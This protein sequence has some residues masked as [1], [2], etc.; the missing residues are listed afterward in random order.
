MGIFEATHPRRLKLIISDSL[1]CIGYHLKGSMIDSAMPHNEIDQMTHFLLLSNN[2]RFFQ[3]KVNRNSSIENLIFLIIDEVYA[4]GCIISC[5]TVVRVKHHQSQ[6]ALVWCFHVNVIPLQG[7]GQPVFARH[8]RA[9]SLLPASLSLSSFFA[10]SRDR[11]NDRF[12]SLFL[13]RFSFLSIVRSPL[14]PYNTRVSLLFAFS[15]PRVMDG[16]NHSGGG[17]E[18]TSGGMKPTPAP[19]PSAN[20]PPPFL[21]KTYDMV[22]DPATDSVVSWSS[23]NNSFVVWN[24]PEFARDLLPKYF[25]HNNFSS[26]VRQLN[27]YGF[28]KVDPDRWEFANE[29]FLRGQKHLLKSISRRKPA[30]GQSHQQST[31]SHA[32]SSSVGAC[33]EV[34]KFGL[35]EEVERLKRDKNVLMQELVRLR[36]QQQATDEQL[37]TMVQRLHGM[38]QRQQQMMSFLAKAM[39]SPGFLAQFVQQQNEGNRRISEA[40]K[41]RRL[42]QEGISETESTT[43]HD[44]Q[45]VRYQPLVNEAAKML[46]QFMKVEAS[47][48]I[49]NFSKNPDNFLLGDAS[50]S[51]GVD[52]GSSTS[53]VSSVTLQEVQPTS[54]QMSI[55][56]VSEVQS[57]APSVQFPDMDA[58]VGLQDSRGN[59]SLPQADVAMHELS[60]IPDI[61]LESIIDLPGDDF[62][63][64]AQLG[65]DG[66]DP[67]EID[68]LPSNPEMDSLFTSDFW[69]DLLV[70]SPVHDVESPSVEGNPKEGDSHQVEN[71][72]DRTQNMDQLTERM[73]LLS[74]NNKGV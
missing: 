9:H 46:R 72:W 19:I 29:G 6:L 74:S 23:T 66:P 54:G 24:P 18:S 8:H 55:P 12:L 69:D 11:P 16:A 32:Q 43:V 28:R 56:T 25:K 10:V 48:R 30:H 47:S 68:G 67:L 14:L 35:E 71:K 39:Q 65:M 70:G 44:G 40:N 36:Q 57:S 37:Q 22:D 26:F 1:N 42:R 73:G 52:C 34:G 63:D 58:I 60:Q 59:P 50:P 7:K 62:L 4:A 53:R 27:T 3:A 61:P 38:E 5:R 33:V 41:K 31:Q 2:R 13:S 20:A 21:S 49:E 15:S 64:P 17:E 45:I 51:V